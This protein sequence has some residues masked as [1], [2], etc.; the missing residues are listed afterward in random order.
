MT[1]FGSPVN[2]ASRVTGV[3]RRPRCWSPRRPA[4][5]SATTTGSAGRSPNAPPQGHQGTTSSCS[6][7]AAPRTLTVSACVAPPRRR[8][9]P[10]RSTARSPSRRRP[11]TT[12][13]TA[14]SAGEASQQQHH[15]RMLPDHVRAARARCGSSSL[16]A[17]RPLSATAGAGPVFAGGEHLDRT[18]LQQCKHVIHETHT[19]TRGVPAVPAAGSRPTSRTPPTPANGS[20]DGFRRPGSPAD[21]A[22]IVDREEITVIGRLPD[23]GD[24]ETE[25]RAARPG[26]PVPWGD[27]LRTHAHRRG[28]GQVRPQ[29]VLGRGDRS[30]RRRHRRANPVHPHRRSGDDPAQSSR[31]ARCW[32]PWSTPASRAP[33]PTRW[34]GRSA[35]SG[36]T[37]RSGWPNCARRCPRSTTCARRAPNSDPVTRHLE[38]GAAPGQQFGVAALLDDPPAVHHRDRV[39]VADGGEAGG[40]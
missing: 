5:R 12:A 35:S 21:P 15:R 3:A 14:I 28:A 2:L 20:P 27:P 16:P 26:V 11:A 39:R 31:N 36:S 9:S 18:D 19:C 32:T 1:E 4:I 40:R 37:P 8:R 24:E 25:A 38:V 29:G 6:A 7:P 33:V 30:V 13:A 23:A 22:V 34:P 17:M 10:P